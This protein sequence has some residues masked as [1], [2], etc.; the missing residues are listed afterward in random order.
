MRRVFMASLMIVALLLATVGTGLASDKYPSRPIT[1]VVA[2]GAGG[3]TDLVN[4]A[5]AEG[6]RPVLGFPINV[7]NMPGGQAGIATEYVW[8]K[9]HDGYTILGI[10][11]TGLFMPANG[12]H[13]TTTKDW[14]YFMAGG[15]PGVIAVR[16]D[17]PYKTFSDLIADMKA[18]PGQ[19]KVAAGSPGG[20]WQAKWMVVKKYA[21]VTEN[22]IGYNGS[23]PSI[24]AVLTG[25]VDVVH[26]SAGEM[27][28]YIESGKLRPLVMT[29]LEGAT[30]GGKKVPSVAEF[31]PGIEKDFPMPQWLG[32]A[33]PKDTPK[34]V[35]DKI[36]EAFIAAMKSK[37]V[38]DILDQQF[39]TPM[40][41]YGEKAN[42]LARKLESAFCWLL[43]DLKMAV[44]NPADL[45]IPRL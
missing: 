29:E 36:T 35:K 26:A 3:G 28:T 17:S 45:G 10:S 23:A 20:L 2:F 34:E 9:P 15:S 44:K 37:P 8:T 19:V 39:A 21:G 5:L 32:F 40:G 16:A 38:K 41:Y 33:I 13:Y 18:R 12:G 1:I 14:D 43:W 31:L 7:I 11:E 4:R 27:R 24:V 30:L 25:E 22:L 42:A 6:M